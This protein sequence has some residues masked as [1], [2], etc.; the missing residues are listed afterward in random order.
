MQIMPISDNAC[1]LI[2]LIGVNYPNP[3][4]KVVA[5]LNGLG[6]PFLKKHLNKEGIAVAKDI[7]IKFK[8]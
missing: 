7:K 8:I 4:L 3:V 6:G 1:E 2:C 5:W